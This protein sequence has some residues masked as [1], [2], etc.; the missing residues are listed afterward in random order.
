M[1]AGLAGVQGLIEEGEVQDATELLGHVE[2]K[3]VELSRMLEERIDFIRLHSDAFQIRPTEVN[4]N[5]V[6]DRCVGN[7]R[8]AAAS[9][10]VEIESNIS[11]RM[12]SW[13]A[14]KSVFSPGRWITSFGMQ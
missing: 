14:G 8:E 2:E 4:L 11:P 10:G 3:R 13:S 1:A 5:L 9:K 6:V 12:R 7:Y